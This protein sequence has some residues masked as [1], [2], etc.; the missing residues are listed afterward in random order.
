MPIDHIG[1]CVPQDTYEQTLKFYTEALKPL[2]YGV[3]MQFG[4]FVAGMGPSQATVE[5]YNQ[6]D[7]WLT[8]VP[9]APST[10]AHIA[11]RAKGGSSLASAPGRW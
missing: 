1:L 11:F 7:F 10:T 2:G 5:G 3:K 9:V 8:G 4:P 6:A